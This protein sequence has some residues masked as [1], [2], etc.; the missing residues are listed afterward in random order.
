MKQM[1]DTPSC[2]LYA[3]LKSLGRINNGNAAQILIAGNA[4]YGGRLISERLTVPSFISREIVH[5]KPGDLP[6]PLFAP[7]EQSARQ[8]LNLIMQNRGSDP[9]SLSK[10][11]KRYMESCVPDMQDALTNCG[12]DGMLF[13]NGVERIETADDSDIKD[14]LYIHLVFFIVTGC[15]GDPARAIEYTESFVSDQM[16]S[17]L[18]TVETTVTSFF[19]TTARLTGDIRLGLLRIV[20]NSAR[21][22]L[23]PLTTDPVGS[24]IGSLTG[25]ENAITDVDSDVSR[26]H[27]RI[28]L[29][30]G[31]WLAQG[32]G[33]TNGSFLISGVDR[34]RQAIEPPDAS[35]PPTLPIPPSRFTTETRFAWAPRRASWSFASQTSPP[36]HLRRKRCRYLHQPM[37]ITAPFRL[38]QRLRYLFTNIIATHFFLERIAP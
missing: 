20:G 26:Q 4:R 27:L 2:A 19:S 35:A 36:T 1:A 32:L 22:P 3:G 38:R 23:R 29:Q 28:W 15:L 17:T 9:Q 12:V 13:R 34:C 33:S 31:R 11:A 37:Q 10:V 8:I 30:D 6:E 18:G 14:R 16:L 25:D 5:A 7:F 24:I 21:P